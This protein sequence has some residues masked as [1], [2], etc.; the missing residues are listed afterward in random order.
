ML[1]DVREENDGENVEIVGE[2]L[3]GK[4]LVEDFEVEIFWLLCGDGKVF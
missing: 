4:S 2:F 3:V 1:E